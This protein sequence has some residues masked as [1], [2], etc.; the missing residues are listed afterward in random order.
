M[1]ATKTSYWTLVP[2]TPTVADNGRWTAACAMTEGYTDAE[3]SHW[4][5]RE[6]TEVVSVHPAGERT[7]PNCYIRTRTTG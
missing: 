3:H 2:C 1:A 4:L 7:E 6:G 5:S